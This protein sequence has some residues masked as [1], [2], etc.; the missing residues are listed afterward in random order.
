MRRETA[1]RNQTAPA[2]PRARVPVRRSRPGADRGLS[3]EIREPQKAWT[4]APRRSVDRASCT[5]PTPHVGVG[6]P[7]NHKMLGS[8]KLAKRALAVHA[9]HPAGVESASYPQVTHLS[10]DSGRVAGMAFGRG[11]EIAQQIRCGVSAD[12]RLWSARA[13]WRDELAR[14]LG[15]RGE[16]EPGRELRCA[17]S[18]EI[19]PARGKRSPRPAQ[20]RPVNSRGGS[21]AMP[22]RGLRGSRR[23]AICGPYR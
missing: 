2:L 18:R 14:R 12:S 22:R 3:M 13:T 7:I 15:T 19:S 11:S 8:R 9:G 1:T 6:R 16:A 10:D 20:N 23:S 21:V 17:G 4:R 5:A